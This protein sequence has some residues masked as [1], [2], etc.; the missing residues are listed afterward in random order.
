MNEKLVTLDVRDDIRQGRQPCAK[1]TQAAADLKDGEALRLIA[2]FEPVPLFSLLA[3]KGFAH[4]AN[5]LGGG[6]WEVLFTRTEV[7]LTAENKA[8]SPSPSACG[9]SQ[10]VE[11]DARGLEPPQPMVKILEAVAALP[12]C[13]DDAVVRSSDLLQ[14][15]KRVWALLC[16]LA[17]LHAPSGSRKSSPCRYLATG[18]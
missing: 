6:D 14:R 12:L 1:I 17:R 10:V 11:V 4:Q 8:T 16:R 3:S 13:L 7:P 5:P 15:G 2:P 9:C 18:S